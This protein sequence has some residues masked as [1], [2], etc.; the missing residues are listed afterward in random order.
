MDATA[1]YTMAPPKLDSD[2]PEPTRRDLSLL[3]LEFED[4]LERGRRIASRA[5]ELVC[6]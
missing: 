6:P 2:M 4:H 5:R 3:L 1:P